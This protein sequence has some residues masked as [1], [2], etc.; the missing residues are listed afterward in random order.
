[1]AS[2]LP[3]E[4]NHDASLKVMDLDPMVTESLVMELFVQAAPVVKVFMPKDKLSQQHSGTA[5]V[6]FQS[7]ADADYA[8]RI[9]RFIKLYGKQIRIK[10]KNKDKIDVGANL[11]IGNLDQDVDERILDETFIQ[12]GSLLS[13]PKI[14]RDPETGVS[15]GYGFVSYDNFAAS[16][17]AIEA[18]DGQ[19]LCNKP[20]SV[21]YARKKDSTE[22]H[23]SQAERI[24]AASRVPG[25]PMPPP[26]QPQ[27]TV[28]TITSFT[29]QQS[30]NN[31][32][33]M[34]NMPPPP[35]HAG[36][37]N[38]MMMNPHQVYRNP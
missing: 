25:A 29:Q 4:R 27:Y 3:Q 9:M 23:G 32:N 14:M 26:Q 2:N 18:L 7:E 37:P 17:A 11:F 16:D 35:P 24:I 20:I 30:M 21:S 8:L 19:F 6:E 10:K 1:M 12:F 5:F 34:N 13:T 36:M 28:P 33:N 22:R 31:I 38:M 15:K